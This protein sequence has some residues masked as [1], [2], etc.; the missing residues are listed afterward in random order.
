MSRV[1]TSS[2]R[3]G[4]AAES[5]V[6]QLVPELRFVGDSEDRHIDAETITLLSPSESLP[7]I[8][9]C[10]LEKGHPVEIKSVMVVYGER[11]T[12]GR[13]Y[14]RKGQH[15]L[16]LERAGSYLFAVCEPSSA[17]DVLAMKVVPASIVDELVSSWIDV[18][19]D[20]AESAYA[21]LTW[22]RVFS[23]DEI[24]RDG[25]ISR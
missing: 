22:S 14:L 4:D 23:Q 21:Q 20:R 10:V 24:S 19:A 11:Q 6:L 1:A 9:T 13:F 17:R 5:A 18:D 25:G 7:F 12:R 8:G 16:L 2:R 15:Q 3:G